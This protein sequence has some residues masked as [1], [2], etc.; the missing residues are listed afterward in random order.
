M[1]AIL[2]GTKFLDKA[3]WSRLLE[4][5]PPSQKHEWYWRIGTICT[6]DCICCFNRVSEK[7]NLETKSGYSLTHFWFDYS[8]RLAMAGKE[9]LMFEYNG[10]RSRWII[11]MNFL[12]PPPETP[13]LSRSET[14]RNKRERRRR[15]R[16]NLTSWGVFWDRWASTIPAQHLNHGGRNTQFL[17]LKEET[18][19]LASKL[20]I[21]SL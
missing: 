14:W 15:R 17:M 7:N 1:D 6:N 21:R 11:T 2:I 3:W 19:Y 20:F 8:G 9:Q 16:G 4:V 10:Y 5:L 12:N 18:M 13:T